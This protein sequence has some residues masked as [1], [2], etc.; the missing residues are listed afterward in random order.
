M[1]TPLDVATDR[2]APRRFD[3]FGANLVRGAQN[4]PF[5]KCRVVLAN[6]SYTIFR[7]PISGYE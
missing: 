5:R 6:V 4:L 7:D 2:A 3:F 1:L